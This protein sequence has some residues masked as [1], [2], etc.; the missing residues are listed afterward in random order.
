MLKENKM[1]D[2]KFEKAWNALDKIG[3]PM[4]DD[5][6]SKTFRISAEHNC[7]PEY[8]NE[9]WAD[10]YSQRA[11][12]EFGVNPKIVKILDKFGLHAEWLN[13]GELGVYN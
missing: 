1:L 3:V 2:A 13:A 10:Y 7:L 11:D 4:F 8:G 9:I 12:W 5:G 6:D